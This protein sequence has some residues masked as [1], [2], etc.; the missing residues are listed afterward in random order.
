VSPEEEPSF[1]TRLRRL[2][3]EAGTT[4]EELALRAGLTPNAVGDLERGKTR[5]PYPH[6]VRSLADA[7]ELSEDERASLLAAVPKRGG[8][9]TSSEI[10]SPVSGHRPHPLW[11]SRVEVTQN[12][13]EDRRHRRHRR[14]AGEK[15][16]H[17]YLWCVTTA[18]TMR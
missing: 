7:L 5:R 18:V 10:P 1:G 17:L 4:Q 6:T 11:P 8:S 13:P 3:E 16:A 14:H 2:R 12:R 9:R 15:H